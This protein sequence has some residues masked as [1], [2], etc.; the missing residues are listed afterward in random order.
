[1]ITV[2]MFH[3]KKSRTKTFYD[4][5]NK[6]VSYINNKID[7]KVSI[8]DDSNSLEVVASDNIKTN[9]SSTKIE[10][11][12]KKTIQLNEEDIEDKLYLDKVIS[13][14]KNFCDQSVL[15]EKFSY[16]PIHLREKKT[17]DANK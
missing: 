16:T 17:K 12:F 3:P 10:L 1:M 9:N 4:I 8:I 14:I 5:N 11:T 13:E 7:K 6:V 15:I 2:K